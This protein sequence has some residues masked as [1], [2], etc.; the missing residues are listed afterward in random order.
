[1]I[2]PSTVAR[3]VVDVACEVLANE[4][5]RVA[6]RDFVS[7]IAPAAPVEQPKLLARAELAR[8]LGV[9]IAH[10]TR[11]DPPAVV[12]GDASTKRYDL[13]E[14]RAWLAARKPQATTPVK[15]PVDVDVSGSLAA[16]GLKRSA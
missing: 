15:K 2:A 1:L 4:R 13:D 6:A 12:V 16:A 3:F 8:R 7:A 5:L 11:L 9:S 10:V 14:V